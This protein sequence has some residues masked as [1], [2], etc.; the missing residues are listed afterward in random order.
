MSFTAPC[1]SQE[2][3][4]GVIYI[5]KVTYIH[6][7]ATATIAPAASRFFPVDTG[8]HLWR[9]PVVARHIQSLNLENKDSLDPTGSLRHLGV[10][11]RGAVAE[12]C[13]ALWGTLRHSEDPCP[14]QASFTTLKFFRR[15]PGCRGLGGVPLSLGRRRSGPGQSLPLPASGGGPL[16]APSPLG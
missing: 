12:A 4:T 8:P 10:P 16:G 1:I 13:P 14:L 15:Q 11:R 7:A 5:H 6:K 2:E 9:A 3:N